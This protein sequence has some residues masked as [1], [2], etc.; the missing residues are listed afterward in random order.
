ML[1]CDK[2]SKKKTQVYAQKGMKKVF[3][4]WVVPFDQCF[5]I[6]RSQHYGTKLYDTSEVI[7]R[8]VLL[9]VMY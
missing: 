2:E 5:K 3:I 9:Y 7:A 1:V 8:N 4:S 6:L